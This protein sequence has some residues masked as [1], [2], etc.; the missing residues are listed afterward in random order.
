MRKRMN[1][2]KGIGYSPL[3]EPGHERHLVF[4][5]CY[6]SLSVSIVF[7][8][9]SASVTQQ[10]PPCHLEP[11]AAIGLDHDDLRGC[12]G[13]LRH[14]RDVH[15]VRDHHDVAA[16]GGARVTGD[17]LANQLRV[18]RLAIG[19]I[20]E[21]RQGLP[22]LGLPKGEPRRLAAAAPRARVNARDRSADGAQVRAHAAGLLA[23]GIGEVALRGAVVEAE[24][25]RVAATTLG[26][27][28]AH[29][30]HDPAAAH[31]GF[32]RARLARAAPGMRQ[33]RERERRGHEGAPA[34]RL[35]A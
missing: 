10:H 11:A 28:M 13:E 27:C 30:K 22:V 15:V 19:E 17:A 34:H 23:A 14:R 12:H 25:G 35:R 24:S 6:P 4:I 2:D 26:G 7:Q 18:A 1:T 9:C 32:D 20:E 3:T 8:R 16:G 21:R 33:E 5:R 31:E 29:E